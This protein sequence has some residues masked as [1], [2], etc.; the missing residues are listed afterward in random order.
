MN[1]TLGVEARFLPHDGSPL[2]PRA[3][4][5]FRSSRMPYPPLPFYV[6]PR[7]RCSCVLLHSLAALRL[8][9][10]LFS[11][12]FLSLPFILIDSH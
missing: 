10:P 6:T 9:F 8:S 7:R 3:N 5:T 11:P 1:R 12:S 2:P 4:P